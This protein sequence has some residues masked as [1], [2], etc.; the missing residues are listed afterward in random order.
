[1]AW[2]HQ[3]G[4]EDACEHRRQLISTVLQGGGRDRVWLLCRGSVSCTASLSCM[5]RVV[6]VG[7]RGLWL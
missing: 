3:C 4:V 5:E 7:V 2:L 1:M 6:V